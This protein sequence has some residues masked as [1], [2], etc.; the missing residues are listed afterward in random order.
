MFSFFY[1]LFVGTKEIIVT[2]YFLFTPKKK[3]R[4][5]TECVFKQRN[6][7]ETWWFFIHIFLVKCF[8]TINCFSR[9]PSVC[10]HITPRA[11]LDPSTILTWYCLGSTPVKVSHETVSLYF[12]L[13]HFKRKKN[14][15]I[16][17]SHTQKKREE[18][19]EKLKRKN[20]YIS[21]NLE[22]IIIQCYENSKALKFNDFVFC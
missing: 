2:Y 4:R 12:F 16:I 6:E 18:K 3:I 15:V 11:T 21:H 22:V 9:V 19:K 8:L 17:L 13:P 14:E 10:H 5:A 1:S 7:N 20:E